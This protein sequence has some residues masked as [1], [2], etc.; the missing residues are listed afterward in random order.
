[1]L[2]SGFY[3]SYIISW[4]VIY[5]INF[6]F[7]LSLTFLPTLVRLVVHL[8]TLNETHIQQDVS[9]PGTGS[10]QRLLL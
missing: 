2:A 3:L 6:F 4:P 7:F 1:M 10:S 9:G 8:I 5:L